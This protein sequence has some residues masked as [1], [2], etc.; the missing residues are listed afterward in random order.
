MV[1]LTVDGLNC[2]IS[3]DAISISFSETAKAT[4]VVFRGRELMMN[5]SGATGDPDRTNSF[6]C[7]YHVNGKTKN[8]IPTRLEVIAD[9][10]ELAH[11]AYVDDQSALQLSYHLMVRGD[12]PAVFGYVVAGTE[13]DD[14]VIN[15]LRTVYRFD[16]TLFTTGYT[17]RRQGLQPKAQYMAQFEKLQDETY[18]FPDACRYTN[19]YVYSKYDYAGYFADNDFWGQYG[20][21]PDG[22]QWGAWFM[23]QDKSC[24]PSGPMKQELLVHYDSIILNYMTGAHFGTGDFDVPK[25]W[26][27]LYGPWCMYFN[28]AE[29]AVADAA[30]FAACQ[31][32]A[33]PADWIDEPS[34]YSQHV[35]TVSGILSLRHDFAHADGWTVVM[36]SE[37]G[38][39]FRQKAGR[40]YYTRADEQG[41]FEFT[42]VQ[43]GTYW[44]YAYLN[45]TADA[46]E[47]FLGEATVEPDGQC[48]KGLIDVD[49]EVLPMEW[50]IGT[51][52]RTTE[53]FVFS[54]QLRNYIWM[55]LTPTNL[56]YRIGGNDDW[57]YLQHD[58]GVW[59]IE[60]ER[61]RTAPSVRAYRLTV[62]LAAATLKTM[63]SGVADASLAIDFNGERVF[64]GHFENDRA[65]YRSSVTGGEAHTVELELSAE[66]MQDLNTIS[67]TTPDYIMYDMIK[68][69]ALV[70]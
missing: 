49:N 8:L 1:E 36:T 25:G 23:P 11:V 53:P 10:P 21:G 70:D 66:D 59:N 46:H 18:R 54:D 17:A 2:T 7:D 40:I 37:K 16:S 35:G 12:T 33:M 65:A 32:A 60:F 29:D 3:N 63:I 58:G 34:L 51:Y 31:R 52:S 56:T 20:E 47:Y 26:R 14:L 9:T 19:S 44:L 61:P 4:S 67:F 27:K 41:M 50:Q 38:D 48:V 39:Y 15:E 28:S 69:E 43:P 6:Y 30:A 55:G 5:L 24:Y 62:C 22:R 57:Y 64:D 45:R 13:A 68:L 42:G